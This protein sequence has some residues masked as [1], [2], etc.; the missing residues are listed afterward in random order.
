MIANEYKMILK[1][2]I[3]DDQEIIVKNDHKKWPQ[4]EHGK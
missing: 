1:M 2:I 4:N 3:N